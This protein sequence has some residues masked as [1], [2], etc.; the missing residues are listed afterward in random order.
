LL[1]YLVRPERTMASSSATTVCLVGIVLAVQ[2][3]QNHTVCISRLRPSLCIDYHHQV[4]TSTRNKPRSPD[5][6]IHTHTH[7]KTTKWPT[8]TSDN[9]TKHGAARGQK[10]VRRQV[11]AA[12]VVPGVAGSITADHGLSIRW[13]L[14]VAVLST[15][16]VRI[17]PW[18]IIIGVL[19]V[20]DAV[21]IKLTG[22]DGLVVGGENKTWPWHRTA[23]VTLIIFS[24]TRRIAR[25]PGYPKRR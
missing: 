9:H 6:Y 8:L 23:A 14:A 3:S 1:R 17:G 13:S 21:Q 7:P 4:D 25:P 2:T 18:L 12:L 20:A 11:E 10:N 15:L 5:T 22:T 24:M 16:I 19:H